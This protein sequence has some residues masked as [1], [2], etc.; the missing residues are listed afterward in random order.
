MLLIIQKIKQFLNLF[1]HIGIILGIS[2][3]I[4]LVY[5]LLY[6]PI[7]TKHGE[8]ITVPD[9]KGVSM[10]DLEDILGKRKLRYEITKDSSFS[11]EYP[12]FVVL[13]QVPPAFSF[14]KENRKIYVS[15]N[16][17]MPP[18]V[19][20]PNLIDGSLKNAQMVLKSYD[21]I[22]GEIEYVPDLAQNSVKEQFY[23]NKPIS[24]GT[25]LPKGSS[26]DLQVGD[27]MGNQQLL[28]PDIIGM[29]YEEAEILILGSNL[30]IGEIHTHSKGTIT[31]I[32]R[33]GG[34]EKTITETAQKGTIFQQNPL[35]NTR[36]N[37]DTPIEIWVVGDTKK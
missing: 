20:M 27:G 2:M 34:V 24:P 9:L 29:N 17:K 28:T 6:L 1:I 21:I 3:T 37:V 5:F 35:P 30:K 23:K 12:P 11:S 25:L 14:V 16:A 22:L 31:K 15:L 8:T 19:K 13:T 4:L 32:M 7:H 33:Q 18:L 10:E 26:I 36:I